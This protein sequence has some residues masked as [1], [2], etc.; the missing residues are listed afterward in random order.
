MRS[1]LF[2]TPLAFG[3]AFPHSLVRAWK[4]A[5]RFPERVRHNCRPSGPPE[6]QHGYPPYGQ[7]YSV[8][9]L[10][11]LLPFPQTPIK[12]GM[13]LKISLITGR[14]LPHCCGGRWA[15]DDWDRLSPYHHAVAGGSVRLVS[16][17]KVR[18][19]VSLSVEDVVNC[20]DHAFVRSTAP[21]LTTLIGPGTEL[22]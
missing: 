12:Q 13:I 8:P 1:P 2:S 18:Q 14:A 4:T 20:S 22:I 16:I 6:Y 9:V 19:V 15:S 3:N 7:G 21:H 17:I 5:K 10:R 11:T